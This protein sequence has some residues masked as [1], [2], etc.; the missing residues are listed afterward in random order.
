MLSNGYEREQEDYKRTGQL[1]YN[2]INVEHFEIMKTIRLG[3]RDHSTNKPKPRPLLVK[4]SNPADKWRIIKNA[5]NLK[6]ACTKMQKCGI[7]PDIVRPGPRPNPGLF[8]SPR[9]R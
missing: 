5:K 3:M 1:I 4:L 8:C 6:F 7:M 2:G 9:P